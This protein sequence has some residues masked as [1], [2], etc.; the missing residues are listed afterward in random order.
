MKKNKVNHQQ[1][2][3]YIRKTLSTL[4]TKFVYIYF[5]TVP[6][7]NQLYSGTPLHT[8]LYGHN[9]NP[10]LKELNELITGNIFFLKLDNMR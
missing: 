7:H 8:N 10:E 9:R 4:I 3:D 2:C 5:K 6:E 1:T